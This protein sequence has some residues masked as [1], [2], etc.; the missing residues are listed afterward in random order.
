[1]LRRAEA[2]LGP[3]PT[4]YAWIVFGSEGRLEQAL[5]TDQDNALVYGAASPEAERYFAALAERVVG[6]L[7]AARFPPC[8]GGFMATNWCR[9]LEQWQRQFR[10]WLEAPQPRALVEAANFFDF[11][12]VYGKLSL[13]PLQDVLADAGREQIFLAHLARAALGFAPPL[14]LFRHIR[15]EDG[16]VDLK[17]GGLIPIVSLARLHALQA[18]SRARPTLERL[19]AAATAGTLSHSGAAT[20]A[21]AFRFLLRL[22]LRT[23]LQALRAGQPPD[24]HV[25]LE[26][27]TSLERR[28][29]KETFVAIGEMQQATALRYAVERLG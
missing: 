18:G 26:T 6:D 13:E 27:L 7:I 17:K 3:P 14:G 16:G 21:E 23:Q 28:H 11:R 19:A 10:G 5:L 12:G 22:R 8:R 24:N 15:Q 25:R 29:L 20:L 1:L 4:P 9:P 2:D